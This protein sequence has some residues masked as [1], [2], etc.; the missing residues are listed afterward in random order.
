MLAFIVCRNFSVNGGMLARNGI[1]QGLPANEHSGRHRRGSRGSKR[2]VVNLS[3]NSSN[4]GSTYSDTS[5]FSLSSVASSSSTTSRISHNSK[6]SS[7]TTTGISISRATTT[8]P[9]FE[10]IPP[11]YCASQMEFIA[12][13]K[14]LGIDQQA[15]LKLGS[16]EDTLD[17]VIRTAKVPEQRTKLVDDE[18][19]GMKDVNQMQDE[20]CEYDF[21]QGDFRT[22]LKTHIW[23][24]TSPSSAVAPTARKQSLEAIDEDR[25]LVGVVRYWDPSRL[26]ARP[27]P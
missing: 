25:R 3:S 17:L 11:K 4:S 7:S 24:S 1:T 16:G 12:S 2:R 20:G 22:S 21:S 5:L 15:P 14:S 9:S 27:P 8:L 19:N 23:A 6:E 26:S 10:E 13:D 18:T